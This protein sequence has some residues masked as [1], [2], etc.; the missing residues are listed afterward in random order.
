MPKIESGQTAF[1]PGEP[2]ESADVPQLPKAIQCLSQPQCD[3]YRQGQGCEHAM[4]RQE[5][6]EWLERLRGHRISVE[7]GVRRAGTSKKQKSVEEFK[8]I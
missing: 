3:S 7:S 2:I 8:E 1:Q 5:L 6:I 4:S